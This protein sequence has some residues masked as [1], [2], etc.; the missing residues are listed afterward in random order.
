MDTDIP[1]PLCA[2]VCASRVPGRGSRACTLVQ[3]PS[4]PG[5]FRAWKRDRRKRTSNIWGAWSYRIRGRYQRKKLFKNTSHA[6]EHVQSKKNK[7]AR[8]QHVLRRSCLRVGPGGAG[9]SVSSDV[10]TRVFVGPYGARNAI[11]CT[12]LA[13]RGRAFARGAYGRTRTG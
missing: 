9:A 13:A 8:C 1:P 10:S 12:A 6:F 5:H 4:S 2:H 7:S 11:A 3:T